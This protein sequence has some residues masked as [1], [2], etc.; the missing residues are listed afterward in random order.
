MW[1]Q[2]RALFVLLLAV[3]GCPNVAKNE[4]RNLASVRLPPGFRID[5]YADSVPG[6]RS[7]ALGPRGTVFVGSRDLGAGQVYALTDADGDQRAESVR[8]IA[9]GLNS[10]NGVAVKDGALYV[11][12]LQR[13]IRYDDIESHLDA[14]PAPV[15][16]TADFPSD[17]LHSWKYL[18]FGPDGMLYVPVGFPCDACENAD[19][20][21]GTILRMNP[22]GGPLSIYA[23]GIR[24]TVGFDF[25]GATSELWF[26]DNGRD[27]LG[28][29]TPPDELNMA[30]QTGMN[31][32]FPYCHGGDI[33]DPDFTSHSCAEFT[34]PAMKLGAHVAALGMVFYTGTQFPAQYQG[35]IF[36]AEHG[37]A[38]RSDYLGYRL[39]LV[40]L[41]AGRAVSYEVF[42]DGFLMDGQS[43]ARPVD[44]LVMP[45]GA[46]LFSDDRSSAVYRISYRG[47]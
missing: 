12:E 47:I 41:D 15:V 5:V 16:I 37:S 45:D 29:E 24:N 23:S 46:L 25:R 26:T 7:M 44:V 10:P 11:A 2:N 34:P 31:F 9:Q 4:D 28:D 27:D 20:R 22:A 3:S 1:V 42:A 36:I 21:F 8:V 40:R 17:G 32:G 33:P 35:Q 39:T 30:S 14:P 19:P 43:W 13:I 18:R 6:A 38:H